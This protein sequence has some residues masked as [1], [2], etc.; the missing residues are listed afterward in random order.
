ML[1]NVFKRHNYLHILGP[2]YTAIYEVKPLQAGGETTFFV[3]IKWWL[4]L[5]WESFLFLGIMSYSSFH[6]KKGVICNYIFPNRNILKHLP[7]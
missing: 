4:P 7:A 5:R 6:I 3:V 2:I 1:H